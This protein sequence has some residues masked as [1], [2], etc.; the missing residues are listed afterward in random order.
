MNVNKPPIG[1]TG[2]LLYDN[3]TDQT[4]EEKAQRAAIA[5]AKKH[6]QQADICFV[7]PAALDS[8]QQLNGLAI[9]PAQI[10]LVHHFWVGIQERG[11]G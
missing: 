10:V 2:L 8:E 6:G 3:D 1:W 7:H 11:E 9:V 4:V 5:Y